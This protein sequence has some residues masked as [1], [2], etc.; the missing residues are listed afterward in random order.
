MARLTDN[1]QVETT[2]GRQGIVVD[3]DVKNKA[4]D[5]LAI[6]HDNTMDGNGTPDDP[7]RVNTDVIATKEDLEKFAKFSIEVVDELPEVGR[8]NVIYF[9]PK[10]GAAPDVHDEYVWTNGAFELIGS[11]Q[12]DL[13]NYLPIT[14]GTIKGVLKIQNGQGTGSLWVGA[15]VNKTTLTANQ[16]RL[17]RIVVP[18]FTDIE[19]GAT[20]LGWDSSGD[21]NVPIINNSADIVGF[22]GSK[23][24]SNATSPM[25]ISFCV[26]KV[27]ESTDAADKVYPLAM[28][29]NNAVF[30][31]QPTYNGKN[32]TTTADVENAIN[33]ALGDIESALAEV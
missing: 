9:V 27:R 10:D 12:V 17:A 4:A 14:G 23:K 31:V 19:L 3:V 2:V 22:G 13:S 24:I 15:D 6:A 21:A 30:G 1:L 5:L 28:D 20:L 26:A 11:T 32:L 7:L 18:S 8:D 33:N 29:A 25:G 16:R